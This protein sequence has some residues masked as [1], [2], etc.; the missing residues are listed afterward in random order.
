M[1]V[2]LVVLLAGGAMPPPATAASGVSTGSPDQATAAPA[3]PATPAP[4]VL[5]PAGFRG[6]KWGSA[7]PEGWKPGAK[8]AD[9]EAYER[10]GQEMTLGTARLTLLEYL[11]KQGQLVG[12][13]LE[14]ATQ[15]EWALLVEYCRATFGPP[16]SQ[17]EKGQI[18][19]TPITLVATDWNAKY[20]FGTVLLLSTAARDA[21]R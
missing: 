18:W 13:R 2:G 10:P 8:Y 11:F 1:A 19:E 17:D 14:V 9:L 21:T 12:V 3:A 6:L 16:S 4:R 20:R 7:L 15:P 5:D